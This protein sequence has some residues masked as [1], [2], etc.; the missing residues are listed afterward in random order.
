MEGRNNQH[1]GAQIH[2]SKDFVEHVRT[3]HFAVVALCTGL[4]I[5]SV[6]PARTHAKKALQQLG[7]LDSIR[8]S[9]RRL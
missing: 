6:I 2:R 9:I 7:A 1:I 5:L 3:V 8:K 4:I